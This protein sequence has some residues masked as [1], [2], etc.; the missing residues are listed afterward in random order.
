VTH[1]LLLLAVAAAHAGHTPAVE[2]RL[3]DAPLVAS[4]APSTWTDG[5]D[6][7]ITLT[8]SS[9][10]VTPEVADVYLIRVPPGLIVRGYLAPTG[11]WSWRAALAYQ[12][13]VALPATLRASWR[14]EGPLG[15]STVVIA[16]VRPGADPRHRANWI[17][18][19]LILKVRSRVAPSAA[20]PTAL[21]YLTP[22]AL[23]TAAAVALVIWSRAPTA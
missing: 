17:W 22:L 21:P 7:A 13:G 20:W 12:R 3:G 5:E 19:P 2:T 16:F 23:A 15:W 8:P 18:R 9:R 1:V 4:V 6:A 11:S 10:P 14:E